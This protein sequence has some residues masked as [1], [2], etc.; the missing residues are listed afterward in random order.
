M[1]QSNL[2][3]A[4]TEGNPLEAGLVIDLPGTGAMYSAISD[5]HTMPCLSQ[6]TTPDRQYWYTGSG[7]VPGHIEIQCESGSGITYSLGRQDRGWSS[8]EISRDDG[9]EDCYKEGYGI[10]YTCLT[11]I[12][13]NNPGTGVRN[14]KLVYTTKTFSKSGSSYKTNIKTH[15]YAIK[16]GGGYW[17]KLK[18]S[19]LANICKHPWRFA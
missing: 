4:S 15:V 14:P 17:K 1:Y 5:K 19:T 7:N 11:S 10:T 12:I 2:L 8:I 3:L 18:S 13:V 9:G 16:R 6:F